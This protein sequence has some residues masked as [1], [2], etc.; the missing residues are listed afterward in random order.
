MNILKKKDDKKTE[1]EKVAERREE[2][3]A[4]GRKFKYPLQW[5]RY[6]IVT[7][8]ILIAVVIFALVFTG[9]WFALYR[10]DMT[11][12]LLFRATQIFPIPVATVNN[13]D[14]RFSDY[15][16]LYRSSIISV[17]RQFNNQTDESSLNYLR[18]E[19]KRSALSEAEKYTY[20]ISLAKEQNITVSEEEIDEEFARHLTIGGTNRSEASFLKIVE[21][22]FGL[23]KSEY[24]RMLYL[25]LIKAKVSIAID[26][27]ANQIATQVESV[28]ASNNNNYNAVIEALGDKIIYE[29]TGGLVDSKN[30]DGGRASEAMKLEPGQSSGKFISMNGDSY[31]FVKLINKTDIEVNFVSIKIPFTEF[32]ERFA[33]LEEEGKIHELIEINTEE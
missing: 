24:R 9:G 31:Y 4:T 33:I 19:Y 21:D 8:T 12:E 7:S 17:E 18:N 26:D 28:L 11:D 13:E 15:L 10:F 5:T 1:Q 20:A 30:I 2:V 14:V 27:A 25:N 6:R 29:E 23:T 32:G 16:M 3:L 22:N